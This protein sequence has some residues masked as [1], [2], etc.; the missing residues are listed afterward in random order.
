[1]GEHL[2]EHDFTHVAPV[3]PKRVVVTGGAGYIGGHLT[4]LLLDQAGDVEIHIVDD[5]SRGNM[6]NVRRLLAHAE[7]LPGKRVEFHEFEVGNQQKM[8][9]LL[10]KH[11]IEVVFH[12][13]GFAYAS[14]SVEFPLKYFTNTHESTRAMLA[15]MEGAGVSQLIY[16]SS[17]A[18][19]GSIENRQCD[20]PIRENSPQKP[21][22]PYGR[23]KLVSE[24]VIRA[25]AKKQEL[26]GKHF[27]YAMLRYFNVIGADPKGRYGPLP[28]P[29]LKNFGRVVDACFEAVT[30]ERA[31]MSLFGG[32]YDTP[33]GYA[34]RDYIH[35]TDLVHA[36]LKV[37]QAIL[38]GKFALVYNVGI[39]AGYS[40]MEV[41]EACE[42][43]T[44]KK[45][46]YEV[47]PNREGDPPFLIADGSRIAR[48]TGWEGTLSRDLV[49]SIASA[50]RW[51]VAHIEDA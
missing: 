23:S 40:V 19:Y 35:V 9:D 37:M 4:M 17:S 32:S 15:A 36:H 22:S 30:G 3:L 41:V 5:L 34:V 46:P 44:G 16:S 33:D 14:E 24:Q 18:T 47:A 50:W 28:K 2:P 13:A 26:K 38:S 43:A 27:S 31:K 48:H 20:I 45:V 51:R 49:G 6:K 7:P 42:K 25:F 39:G 29:E 1:M 8:Q 10:T 21:V 12:F 11:N